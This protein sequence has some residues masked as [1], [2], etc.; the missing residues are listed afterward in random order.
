[1]RIRTLR[2]A[3]K[4]SGETRGNGLGRLGNAVVSCFVCRRTTRVDRTR[5]RHRN[6]CPQCD[7]ALPGVR[8]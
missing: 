2:R 4:R 5:G 6:L 7:V 3:I 8:E 1:M